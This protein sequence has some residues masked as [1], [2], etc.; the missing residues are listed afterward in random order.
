MRVNTVPTLG[1][2]YSSITAFSNSKP[3]WNALV[4]EFKLTTTT[5]SY[6]PLNLLARVHAESGSP[7]ASI[8]E[9]LAKEAVELRYWS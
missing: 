6:L 9:N 3:A 5:T 1:K 2:S 4:P 8:S 7:E